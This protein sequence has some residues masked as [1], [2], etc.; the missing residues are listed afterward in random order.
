MFTFALQDATLTTTHLFLSCCCSHA[1]SCSQPGGMDRGSDQLFRKHCPLAREGI[2]THLLPQA[3][4]RPV[5]ITKSTVTPC[6]FSAFRLQPEK[7]SCPRVL[8]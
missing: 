8:Q 1:N 2:H 3:D 6:S 5:Q 7:L 4:F